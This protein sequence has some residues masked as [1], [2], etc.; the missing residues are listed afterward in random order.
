VSLA[1][2]PIEFVDVFA[3][4]PLAGNPLAVVT[5]EAMPD[6]DARQT[7]ARELNLSETTFVA[8]APDADGRWPV[9]IHTPEYELPFAGHPSLGTAWV[10]RER[11]G[12]GEPVVLATGGGPVPVAF[13]GEG[14]GALAWLDAPPVTTLGTLAPAR[15]AS[16]LGIE[17]GSID[18][19]APPPTWLDVGPR[20]LVV[21]LA[22]RAV[23][24]RLS[25]PTQMLRAALA[26]QEG[27]GVFAVAPTEDGDLAARMFF[28]AR[29]LR[30]D[31]ATGSA[32]CCLAALLRDAGTTGRV[33]VHQGVEMQR[34]S[35]LH[36]E[37][38]ADGLRVGG[39][40]HPV[41]RGT[42]DAL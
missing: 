2:R 3:E 39:R 12:G 40:V 27:V 13:E 41:L 16:A 32:A 36:L 35:L 4:S 26:E 28:D 25:P 23:L 5:V 17:A 7:L 30:E 31:P 22:R 11:L 14:P 1:H 24:A 34:P 38:G 33:R 10:V 37:I 9:R 29:G 6:A 18:A 19:G 42:L 15:S 20:F 8:T 21:H